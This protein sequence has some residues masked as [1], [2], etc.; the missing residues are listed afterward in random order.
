LRETAAARVLVANLVGE[1]EGTGLDIE[2]HVR[3]IEAHAGGR[4]LD[5][6][7]AHEGPIDDATLGRYLAEGS[8]PLVSSTDVRGLPVVLRN[9]LA[10]GPKLRHDSAATTDGLIEV[11]RQLRSVEVGES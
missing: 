3:L 4:V 1:R 10:P 2:D 11:W 8:M 5:A 6:I 7:L 9:L